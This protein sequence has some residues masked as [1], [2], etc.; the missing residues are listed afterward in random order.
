VLGALAVVGYCVRDVGH[1]SARRYSRTGAV[2]VTGA[3]LLSQASRVGC[4]AVMGVTMAVMLVI[5]T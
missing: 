1:L 4:R 5:M 3:L 2:P